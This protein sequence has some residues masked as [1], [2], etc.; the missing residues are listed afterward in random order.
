MLHAEFFKKT[1]L[2]AIIAKEPKATFCGINIWLTV[3]KLR[4]NPVFIHDVLQVLLNEN[5][6]TV[7]D[8]KVDCPTSKIFTITEE[9]LKYA[10]IT[11]SQRS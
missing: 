7:D 6:V 4:L 10:G 8:I 9:G 1:F 3:Q 11:R 5:L 2:N